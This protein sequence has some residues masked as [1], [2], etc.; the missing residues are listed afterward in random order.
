MWAWRQ[1]TSLRTALILLFVS[2]AGCALPRTLGLAGSARQHAPDASQPT[3]VT[4]AA[5]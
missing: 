3:F 1:L 2:L 4:G 5:R